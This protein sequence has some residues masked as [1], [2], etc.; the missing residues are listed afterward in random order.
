MDRTEESPMV[1]YGSATTSLYGYGG[2]IIR[3]N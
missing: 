1:S 2:D 3:I